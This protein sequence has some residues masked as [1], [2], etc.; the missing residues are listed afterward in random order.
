MPPV[1]AIIESTLDDS[2]L[3]WSRTGESSYVVT[4]PGAHKLK[5]AC[6]LIVGDHA[7]RVEAFV[8]RQPEA[9]ADV[10]SGL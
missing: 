6:N 3:E 9:F 1:G 7:L 10:A 2:G 5:T 8:M 4:L